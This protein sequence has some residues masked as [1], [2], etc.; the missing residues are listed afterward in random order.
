MTKKLVM[1]ALLLLFPALVSCTFVTHDEYSLHTRDKLAAPHRRLSAGTYTLYSSAYPSSGTYD[2]GQQFNFSCIGDP[3]LSSSTS[4]QISLIERQ[5]NQRTQ[6][7][8][9]RSLSFARATASLTYAAQS[10]PIVYNVTVFCTA[11]GYQNSNSTTYKFTM[12]GSLPTPV[13]TP[14]ATCDFYYSGGSLS[15]TSST[16]G[17]R[18]GYSILG[19][20]T[21]TSSVSQ[22]SYPLSTPIYCRSNQNECTITVTAFLFEN[23]PLSSRM[24]TQSPSAVYS[25]NMT[26]SLN[27]LPVFQG[28]SQ[29]VPTGSRVTLFDPDHDGSSEYYIEVASGPKTGDTIVS[30]GNRK[31]I[32]FN[33]PGFVNIT[34]RVCRT[35]STCVQCAPFKYQNFTVTGVADTPVFSPL[36]ATYASGRL[37]TVHWGAQN[38][39]P[40]PKYLIYEEFSAD[41]NSRLR[42]ISRLYSG[43]FALQVGGTVNKRI[44]LTAYNDPLGLAP[45]AS[46]QNYTII[47]DPNLPAAIISSSPIVSG[48]TSPSSSSSSFNLETIRYIALVIF[49][50]IVVSAFITVLIIQYLRRRKRDQLLQRKLPSLGFSYQ[51]VFNPYSL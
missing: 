16:T 30:S 3:V 23:V 31:I 20:A 2:G 48:V 29:V 28:I 12:R 27:T 37:V 6:V 21:Y 18:L 51:Q 8:S 45:A 25:I 22:S 26:R 34:A 41:G 15:I 1:Y 17:Y 5:L 40:A 10:D 38:G 24:Y 42:S 9:S 43:P 33:T 50:P 32:T 19:G 39:S 14:P 11:T 13:I 7:S 47:A 46:S 4:V 44:V 36:G 35:V 49:L